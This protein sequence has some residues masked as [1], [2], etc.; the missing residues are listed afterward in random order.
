MKKANDSICLIC[1]ILQKR[2]AEGSGKRGHDCACG[3]PAAIP[4]KHK[5]GKARQRQERETIKIKLPETRGGLQVGKEESR[6]KDQRLRIGDLRRSS[7]HIMRPEG[8]LARVKRVCQKLK[9]RLEMRLCIERNGDFARKP[10]KSE[11][12]PPN[13]ECD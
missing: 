4:E 8:R 3:V 7:E 13:R 6:R 11:D 5:H 10:W 2:A 12:G 9:L 1:W